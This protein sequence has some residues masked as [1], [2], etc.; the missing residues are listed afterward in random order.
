MLLT[1]SA[2]S[3]FVSIV[4]ITTGGLISHICVSLGLGVIA[5][6]GYLCEL[7]SKGDL[8]HRLHPDRLDPR[9]QRQESSLLKKEEA[10]RA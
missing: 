10:E 4:L 2:I 9:F 5:L 6:F 8:G 1:V 3:F 7:F